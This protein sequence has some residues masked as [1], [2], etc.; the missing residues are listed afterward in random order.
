MKNRALRGWSLPYQA[1]CIDLNLE[2]H[3]LDPDLKAFGAR[4]APTIPLLKKDINPESLVVLYL[5]FYLL[6]DSLKKY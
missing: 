2:S 1:S 3:T 5:T 4:A 6:L